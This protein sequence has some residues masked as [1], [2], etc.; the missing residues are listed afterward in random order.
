MSWYPD[1]G[2]TVI[3]RH[4]RWKLPWVGPKIALADGTALL[5]VGFRGL[6]R[7]RFGPLGYRWR[8]AKLLVLDG[9]QKGETFEIPIWTARALVGLPIPKTTPLPTW[10]IPGQMPHRVDWDELEALLAEA[11]TPDPDSRPLADPFREKVM[12]REFD[13]GLS[14]EEY[15]ARWAQG[16]ISFSMDQ[17]RYEDP[18]LDAW[19]QRL[20]T[21]LFT[22][23]AVM[24]C[25]RHFLTA[26]ELRRLERGE[27]LDSAKPVR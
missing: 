1:L 9:D 15:A 25:R 11:R 4:P 2:A 5:I 27:P 14:P 24:A 16:I 3:V 12:R 23:G 18:I 10:L 8:T 21:I 13:K 17:Y 26:E 6:A 19:V 22:R 7:R 20:G